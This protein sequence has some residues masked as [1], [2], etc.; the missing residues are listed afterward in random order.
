VSSALSYLSKPH[1]RASGRFDMADVQG[2][3]GF[4]PDLDESYIDV[5]PVTGAC[6][7]LPSLPFPSPGAGLDREL[8][9]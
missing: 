6:R 8:A 1:H 5:E 4:D 2:I 9:D 7:A 3:R